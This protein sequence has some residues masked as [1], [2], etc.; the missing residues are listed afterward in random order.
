MKKRLVMLAFFMGLFLTFTVTS[1]A[2]PY[3]F[4]AITDNNS[5]EG[6]SIAGQFTVD[7]LTDTAGVKFLFSNSGPIASSIT[8]IYFDDGSL[9]GIA[10]I[11]NGTGTSFSQGAIPGELPGANNAIPPFVTTAGFS[12]DSDTPIMASGVNPGEEVAIIFSLQGG[13]TYADVLNDLDDGDLR[14]GIH[15]QAIGQSNGSDS[16][17]NDGE[18]VP[19]PEPGTLMLLGAGLVGLWVVRRRK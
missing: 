3:G 17:V 10:S 11:T 1:Y 18:N 19:V 7:V 2:I 16:F 5:G 4:Y 13:K 6:P 12:A 15:V 8:N 14:I 9:L